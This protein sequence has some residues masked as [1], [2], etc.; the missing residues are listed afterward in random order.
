MTAGDPSVQLRLHYEQPLTPQRLRVSLRGQ[1]V[2]LAPDDGD[3]QRAAA[4]LQSVGVRTSVDD[5]GLLTFPV[6]DL[7]RLLDLPERVV[8]LPT[9]D[10][11]TLLHLLDASEGS[12]IVTLDTPR[13]LNVSWVDATGECNEPLDIAATPALLA[14]GVPVVADQETWSALHAASAL[15]TVLARAK[16]NLDGFVEMTT[17]VPQ[18]VESLDVPGLFR[19]DETRFG[20]P[21]S[22]IRNLD[23]VP[24]VVW[25][26]PVPAYDPPPADVGSLPLV[27]SS[28]SRAHLRLLV[29]RL[30]FSRS[31]AVVWPRGTGRRVFSLAA[32]EALDAYPLVLLTRPALL[33]AWRRH[34]D[35]LGRRPSLVT[36]GDVL[37]CPYGDVRAITG[38]TPPAALLLDDLDTL[39]AAPGALAELSSS[40]APF[41]GDPDM[42][43]LTVSSSLP[44][45]LDEVYAFMGVLR[46]GEFRPGVPVASRYASPT[47]RRLNEHAGLYVLGHN[48]EADTTTFRR[49]EVVTAIA[50]E[51]LGRLLAALPSPGGAPGRRRELLGKVLT[52]LR[53]G[54]EDHLGAK[55]PHVLEL[56]LASAGR[57]ERVAVF[58]GSERCSAI[59]AGLAGRR[60]A[61]LATFHASIPDRPVDAQTV[62]VMEYPR[63]FSTLDDAVVEA[64]DSRG[65][66]RVVLVHV[67][68]SLEDRLAVLALARSEIAG[69]RD[70]RAEFSTMEVDYLLGLTSFDELCGSLLH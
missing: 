28:A 23:A 70:P 44:S 40:L 11:R 52:I 42:F 6:A 5:V 21:L 51:A 57:G 25:E 60:A 7:D 43:R 3:S 59:L 17:S 65:P 32:I 62:V 48:G 27:L 1:S 16:V 19:I 50:D 9:G 41:E 29:D 14:L 64:S 63:A 49:S 54:S 31:I 68:G 10:V 2:L 24:G 66:R 58:T 67:E 15:P 53:E 55:I 22:A 56:V 12:V 38:R 37:L 36:D 69:L 20:L 35:L 4:Y 34:L 26:G 61:E 47:A 33:W 39:A 18:Q 30:A 8:V 45:G 46:P 13:V